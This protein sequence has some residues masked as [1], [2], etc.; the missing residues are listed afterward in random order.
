MHTNPYPYGGSEVILKK[1]Y[2]KNT[3]MFKQP[4]IQKKNQGKYVCT[5]EKASSTM[6]TH[7]L[8]ISAGCLYRKVVFSTLI[9][10]MQK[11]VCSWVVVIKSSG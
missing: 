6:D 5:Q 3:E 10:I 4:V 11:I 2:V 9:C 7:Q 8:D 1:S